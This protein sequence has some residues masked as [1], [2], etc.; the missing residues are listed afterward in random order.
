M[1]RS[2]LRA[3]PHRDQPGCFK[4][5]RDLPVAFAKPTVAISGQE[6]PHKKPR[7]EDGHRQRM[8]A[9]AQVRPLGSKAGIRCMRWVQRKAQSPPN[10]PCTGLPGSG[11]RGRSPRAP[12]LHTGNVGAATCPC[13]VE[14]S[15]GRGQGRRRGAVLHSLQL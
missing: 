10:L 9:C 8:W 14:V 15:R 12:K 2:S 11:Q 6:H 5:S 7:L 4:R 13:K 1:I 3:W